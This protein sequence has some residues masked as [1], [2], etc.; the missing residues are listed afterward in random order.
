M[1]TAHR[2][3]VVTLPTKVS[4]WTCTCKDKGKED[5]HALA[6]AVARHHRAMADLAIARDAAGQK[7]TCGCGFYE[8]YIED[9]CQHW[10]GEILQ[11]L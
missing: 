6:L 9:K 1:A 11:K 4:I 2:T 7:E 3:K 5:T 8:K 10:T